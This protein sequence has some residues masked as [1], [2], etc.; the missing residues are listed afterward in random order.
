MLIILGLGKGNNRCNPQIG[1]K[2]KKINS[3]CED[4]WSFCIVYSI[5]IFC[6]I[7]PARTV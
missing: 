4:T 1:F 3:S 6:I 2:L 5:V 7:L